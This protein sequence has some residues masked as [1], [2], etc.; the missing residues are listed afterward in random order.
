[1]PTIRF[2]QH[3]E[4]GRPYE[5]AHKLKYDKDACVCVC[6]CLWENAH[7]CVDVWMYYVYINICHPSS[8]IFV[9]EVR[10]RRTQCWMKRWETKDMLSPWTHLFLFF[11]F[12]SFQ[13]VRMILYFSISPGDALLQRKGKN[14]LRNLHSCLIYQNDQSGVIMLPSVQSVDRKTSKCR[15]RST[16]L[17]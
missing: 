17:F 9:M 7:G 6:L 8:I 1:M 3:S 4:T 11:F 16:E 5:C 2:Y 14:E 15:D 10:G 12:S 13:M